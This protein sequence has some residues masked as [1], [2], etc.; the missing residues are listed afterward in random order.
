MTLIVNPAVEHGDTG[1][2]VSYT[3]GTRPVR[4]A[5][6][7]DAE[8]LSNRPVTNTTGAP[9]AAPAIASTGPFAV[10][11]NQA[12]VRRLTATDP[13]AGDAV[14]GWAITGGADA[15]QFA[16][17]ETTGELSF[18]EAP[19]YESPA[20]VSSGDPPSAAADNE[21]VV[22]VRVTSGTGAR[23][24]DAERTF[25]VRV[26]DETERPGAPE[27]PSF[28]GET[29]ASV[30]VSWR[31]PENTGP[32]ITDYDVQYRE[33]GSGGFTDAQHEGTALTA[34]LTGSKRARPTRCRYGQGTTKEPATGRRR[35]KGG[36]SPR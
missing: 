20:D 3:P 25:L 19:D 18:R 35:A 28:F 33:G 30:R 5:V 9:N 32:P 24:L 27:A 12:A 14:T 15:L 31:A 8:G 6:G 13:D 10:G 36:P 34:A 29:A 22:T 16:V 2:Q 7:N 1:I 11:E 23:Q 21:Y 26:T 4:D 17:G